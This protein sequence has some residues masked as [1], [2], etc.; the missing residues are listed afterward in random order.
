[1]SHLLARLDELDKGLGDHAAVELLE[2]LERT[3]V[4]V[5]DL[6]GV[7][8]TKRHHIIR[9]TRGEIVTVRAL[10][11]QAIISDGSSGGVPS[12]ASDPAG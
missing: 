6:L 12:A 8:N 7:S 4:V 11:D 2:V 3:L 5:H 9:S 1:M 10:V